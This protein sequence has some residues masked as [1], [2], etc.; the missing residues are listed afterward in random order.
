MSARR[1]TVSARDWGVIAVVAAVVIGLGI[2]LL[3]RPAAT[4]SSNSSRQ[5]NTAGV[6]SAGSAAPVR[7]TAP[8]AVS[9]TPGAAGGSEAAPGSAVTNGSGALGSAVSSADTSAGD[10]ATDQAGVSLGDAPEAGVA[11]STPVAAST[12]ASK[13]PK[14]GPFG[15]LARRQPDDPRALGKRDAPVVM[16][17]Y[18]DYRCPFCAQFSRDTEQKLVDKY[19][20]PGTLRIEW[21]DAPIF[22]EQSIKAAMAGRAAG[23]QGRFWEF[24]SAVY[25]D[26]P[27]TGHPDLTD[28][29]LVR[30]ATT[31]G[32]KDL[33]AFRAGLADAGTRK[34]VMAEL[35]AANQIGVPS[36]P[37]FIINGYPLVGSQPLAEF[38]RLIDTVQTL[39]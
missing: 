12:A 19:V 2:Y 32:V 18:S 34:D 1:T 3:V 26:A 27:K 30:Y 39:K 13:A 36:T 16:V 9:A 17:M 5:A 31:A 33:S 6:G 10:S 28:D 38:T 4:D 25:A 37:A 24:T 23:E 7:S 22:G 15:D 14:I 8:P 29:A 20:T 11:G 35:D 21:R